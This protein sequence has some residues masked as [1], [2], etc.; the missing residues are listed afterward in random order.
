MQIRPTSNIQ[1]TQS[2]SLPTR[3]VTERTSSALPVD[4]VEISTEARL[5]ETQATSST[6]AE[7]I[8][9]I[10]AQIAQGQY[11]TSDKLE[12]AISRMFDEFA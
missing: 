4:Q 11:E 6:R 12:I 7:R 8:A 5:L 9:E 1:T 10:R 3:N 2:I